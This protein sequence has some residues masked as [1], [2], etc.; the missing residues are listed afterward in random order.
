MGN[1]KARKVHGRARSRRVL[2]GAAVGVSL[3][4]TTPPATADPGANGPAPCVPFGSAQ[5][6]PGLPSGGGLAG[7]EQLPEFRGEGAPTSVELRTETTSFNRSWEYALVGPDLL[8]RPRVE[9][10]RNGFPWRHVPMPECMRGVLAG[11]SVDDDELIAIDRSGWIYTMDQASQ[12]PITWNWTSA[13]GAPFW[14]GGGRRVPNGSPGTWSL[15]VSSP[16]DNHTYTDIAGRIHYVGWAKMTMVPALTGDGSRIT[17]ADPWLPND[18]SSEIGGPLGSRFRSAYLS[19]AGSTM[20]VMNRYGDMYTR[21]FDYDSSGSDSVF[22]RYSW[23]SQAHKP[24]APNA[25]V[26]T[27][28]R[29]FAAIQLP[30]PDWIH[31][32][33]IPGE[34]TSA[35]SVHSTGIGPG[36]RELRVEGRRDGETGFWHKDPDGPGWEFTATS[37]PL[38]GTAVENPAA[39]RSSD[40]LAPPAPWNLSTTLPARDGAV[41][42]RVLAEV[43][44]PY[45]LVDPQMLDLVGLTARPSEYRFEVDSFDPAATTRPATV[46]AGDGTRIPVLMHTADGMR[47][48]PRGAGLDDEPRHLIGAIEVP[49]DAYRDRQG[50]PAL[51]RFVREWMWG[52]HISAITLDATRDSLVIR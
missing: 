22:F 5:I 46:I 41:D 16:F 17:F 34:I 38:L 10:Q 24:T 12:T 14:F 39:D 9:G 8:A 26:E 32:P 20:F 21:T 52:N 2:A 1:G 3:L 25:G 48:T 50:N 43:S 18:D 13:F 23:D 45:S 36:R 37:A 29:G 15:S 4:V 35:I 49:A 7:F 33:K 27:L 28:D 51:E 42:G 31:Q 40:T 11:I 44:M 47:L 19:A 30:A 6:P